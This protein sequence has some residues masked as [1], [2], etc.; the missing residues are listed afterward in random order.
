MKLLTI[1]LF[2]IF[3]KNVLSGGNSFE[4][5][6]MKMRGNFEIDTKQLEKEFLII[7]KTTNNFE[8]D[9]QIYALESLNSTLKTINEVQHST[10]N[11]PI[12]KWNKLLENL[13]T[14]L[15]SDSI[16]TRRGL[17]PNLNWSCEINLVAIINSYESK[18]SIIDANIENLREEIMNYEKIRH[19][20]ND[21]WKNE[22]DEFSLSIYR[23]L[24]GISTEQMFMKLAIISNLKDE[25]RILNELKFA[26][27]SLQRDCSGDFSFNESFVKPPQQPLPTVCA[28]N[29]SHDIFTL[30][31]KYIKTIC[32][33]PH[34][35]SYNEAQRSCL[36]NGMT[37]L[38]LSNAEIYHDFVTRLSL[39]LNEKCWING[40]QY[41]IG[42]WRST[43]DNLSLYDDMNWLGNSTSQKCL[44]VV[45]QSHKFGVK[46]GKCSS[47]LTSFCEFYR[48]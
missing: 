10:F 20:A 16:S 14:I 45:N 44:Q 15:E 27:I 12:R 24:F 2:A 13:K 4:G 11:D 28:T 32:F 42:K 47:K 37:L 33:N 46:S 3:V 30:T 48:N 41:E 7:E 39:N 19:N 25:R 21:L 31:G 29:Y 9:T 17:L 22:S 6:L 18:I 34:Q 5:V 23:D 26:T 40:R 38:R 8:N 43:P 36:A 1:I 35:L